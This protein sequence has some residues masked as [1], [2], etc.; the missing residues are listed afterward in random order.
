[1][2]FDPADLAASA[3]SVRCSEHTQNSGHHARPPLATPCCCGLLSLC[4]AITPRVQF[5]ISQVTKPGPQSE[6]QAFTD[7]LRGKL[8]IPDTGNGRQLHCNTN[9]SRLFDL[10]ND[11]DDGSGYKLKCLFSRGWTSRIPVND[12]Q[13]LNMDVCLQPFVDA[14]GTKQMPRYLG[15]TDVRVL[16]R[17]ACSMQCTD[18][19]RTQISEISRQLQGVMYV[20]YRKEIMTLLSN[21]G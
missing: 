8:H 20:D 5:C 15:S 7:L 17:Y 14:C 21:T 9:A 3:Q 16:I 12:D 10:V 13:S 6:L 4:D 18:E 1:M 2:L 11:S 19:P